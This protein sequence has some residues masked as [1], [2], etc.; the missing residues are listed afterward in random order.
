MKIN[1]A[2]ALLVICVAAAAAG[3]GAG[4]CKAQPRHSTVSM[5]ST[6]QPV[7]DDRRGR[8]VELMVRDATTSGL[9]G[10]I[11][12]RECRV[13]FRRDALGMSNASGVAPTDDFRGTTSIS[14]QVAELNDQ[15]LVVQGQGKRYVIPH[16]AILL[17][18]VQD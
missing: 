18:E 14:G 11:V 13:Q 6:T 3:A 2:F 15:W 7:H 4:G 8:H 17:I 1:R 10:T 16:G 5:Y 9:A 12:G